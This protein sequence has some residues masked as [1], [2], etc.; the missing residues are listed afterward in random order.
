MTGRKLL[1]TLEPGRAWTRTRRLARTV[2]NVL[3][4]AYRPGEQQSPTRGS[5][6]GASLDAAVA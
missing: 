6:S 1:L 5:D 4:D 2:R 3:D